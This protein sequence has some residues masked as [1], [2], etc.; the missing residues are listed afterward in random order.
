MTLREIEA[1]SPGDGFYDVRDQLKRHVYR[2]SDRAFAA[3]DRARDALLDPDAVAAYQRRLRETFIASLGGLPETACIPPCSTTGVLEGDGYR[4]EKL[5]LE[6]RPRTFVTTNLYVPD[7]LDG[8]TG[9]VLFLCG[10]ASQAKAYPEYQAVCQRLALAGLVVLAQDPIG[11]GERF[12]YWEPAIAAPAI[13]ECCPDHDHSGAQCVPL[14]DSQARYMLHDAL[15]SLDYLA[16]RPEVDPARIGITGNSG[17]GT[18]CSL[19][20]LADPRVAAAAPGTFIMNRQTYMLSG[21]AQDAEQIW[22]GFTARGYDHEDILLAMAPKPVCVLAVTGDF[23]PI[24]GTRRTVERCRR[25]WGLFGQPEALELVVDCAGHAYTP[26]LARAATRFLSRHLLGR[27]AEVDESRVAP[28]PAEALWCTRAGQVREESAESRWVFDASRERLREAEAERARVPASERRA[29]AVAWLRARVEAHRERCDLN[30]RFFAQWRVDRLEATAAV[31]WSQPDL[32]GH[33]VLFRDIDRRGLSLR[34]T[35]ALWDGGTSCLEPHGTWLRQTCADGR[36]VLVLDVSG[37]GALL[38]NPLHAF[39]APDRFYGVIH[40]LAD[41]LHWLDDSLCALRVWDVLRCLDVLAEW[42]G[43]DVG[44]LRL[45]VAG[46][47]GLYGRLAAALDERIRGVEAASGWRAMADWV[48]ERYYDSR[49][50]KS[51]L[52]PGMLRVFDLPD[53]EGGAA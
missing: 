53:I 18:Q 3:G 17:G 11:Q 41:D 42:P 43:A 47:H 21:G 12:S 19:L 26:H 16:A 30:P 37:A 6:S 24:E 28:R 50:I 27:E 1:A 49:D 15:R 51:A 45:R 2:R 14:G 32:L 8:P 13:A 10:H 38:P 31:W 4:I 46:V 9:A 44:D 52:L 22:P 20:M 25:V 29:L 7:R 39:Y 34:V 23:F 40:K 36:A 33:G 48:G 5:I 35:I